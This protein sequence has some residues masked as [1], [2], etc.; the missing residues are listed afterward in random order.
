MK[1]FKQIIQII[2]TNL[3][4]FENIWSR[5]RRRR[6]EVKQQF[7]KNRRSGEFGYKL[8]RLDNNNGEEISDNF[9]AS[10]IKSYKDDTLDPTTAD[11]HIKHNLR[12]LIRNKFKLTDFGLIDSPQTTAQ[13]IRLDS[14]Q[15]FLLFSDFLKLMSKSKN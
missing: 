2:W 7:V 1:L 13:Q 3:F 4:C 9:D 14:F 15:S 5:L 6:D 12:P 10:V 8:D 11:D